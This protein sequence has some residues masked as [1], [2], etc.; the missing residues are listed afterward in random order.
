V[1]G[2]YMVAPDWGVLGV[3]MVAPDWGVF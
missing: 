3:Y 2:V 1:L